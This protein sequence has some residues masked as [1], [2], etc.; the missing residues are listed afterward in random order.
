[1]EG[2]RSPEIAGLDRMMAEVDRRLGGHRTLG[3]WS[4]GQVCN[5]LTAMLVGS[6]DWFPERSPWPIR[7]VLGPILRRKILGRGGYPSGLK[8]PEKYAPKPGLDDRAEAEALRAAV[9]YFSAHPGPFAPHPAIDG[10][11]GED[12]RR[13]HCA[14]AAHHL[15]FVP[16]GP[17]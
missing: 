7:K 17:G 8:L 10:L 9:R 16:P 14:H 2:R 5:H 4:L 11:T 13:F 6:V 1:M 12:W 3:R 15:G